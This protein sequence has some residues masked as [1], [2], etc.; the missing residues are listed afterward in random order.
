VNLITWSPSHLITS[1]KSAFTLA[2]VLITLAIIGVVAAMTIPTL[3]ADYQERSWGTAA[4]VFERR[5]EEALKVM[6]TQQTLAGYSTTQ[7]FVNELSK[8]FKILKT[9]DNNN[10]M[11]CFEDSIYWGGNGT[12]VD[13]KDKKTTKNFGIND[14]GTDLI[15]IQFANGTTALVGYNTLT[16]SNDPAV[17]VCRQDPY[18]NEITGMGCLAMIYDTNGF[19]TPNTF[20]KDLRSIN[21]LELTDDYNFKTDDGTKWGIPFKVTEPATKADCIE[22]FGSEDYCGSENDYWVAALKICKSQGK[23]LPN[24]NQLISLLKKLF[25]T[26]NVNSLYIESSSGLEL[27]YDLAQKFGFAN[28]V[29]AQIYIIRSDPHYYNTQ[30]ELIW[31]TENH[32]Q[33]WNSDRGSS[34][35]TKYYQAVCVE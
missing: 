31:I 19:K 18:S 24:R 13:M 2:E 1:Q 8:H 6:N 21:V 7:E 16:S 12:F 5:L 34:S 3:V 33:E 17:P 32:A 20:G 9:C 29:G 22:M 26:N 30:T 35:F 4:S 10:L 23:N 14:W 28:R 27:D 25:H 11:D 15:G